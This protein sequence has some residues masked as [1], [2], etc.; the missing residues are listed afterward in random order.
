MLPEPVALLLRAADACASLLLRWLE[1]LAEVPLLHRPA[2]WGPLLTA[3]AAAL[4]MIAAPPCR[5]RAPLWLA[6][7]L[8]LPVSQ[9]G[10]PPRPE[11]V[12]LGQFRVMALD[13]GQGTAV[14]VDTAGHR[15]LFDAG[16]AFPGGFE[17]GSAVVAPSLVASGRG[18]LDAL[19]LSHD[20]LDHVG[21]AAYLRRTLT[22]RRWLSSFALSG[23][24]SC[25]GRGWA[26]DGVVF[27]FL[28]LPR[29]RD[30]SDNDRSCV[31]MVGNGRE[32]LLLAGDVG[33]AVERAL[34]RELDGPVTLMFA[35]HHGSGA[36]STRALVRVARPSLVFVSA[37]LGNRYGHPHPRVVARYGAVG[38]RVHQT[39]R[40]GALIWRSDRPGTVLR[41]RVQR[42]PYWRSQEERPGAAG[43][44]SRR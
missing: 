36:S 7:L 15:L 22:V 11:T 3:Q 38:A 43:A 14:V 31:L 13:V 8:W 37:A 1:V 29:P 23:A 33:A 34:V 35:P 30:A 20:D 27:R 16:P 2:R 26:W 39:G 18:A 12:P 41:W 44:P 5:G 24:E 6:G 42:G 28:R 21:G 10:D 4:W 32:R 19:V 25:H 17:T 9:P 40:E